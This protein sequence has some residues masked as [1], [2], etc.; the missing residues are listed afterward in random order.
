MSIRT[1]KK[2]KDDVKKV[3]K[4]EEC[5]ICLEEWED[6]SEGDVVEAYVEKKLE[7]EMSHKPGLFLSY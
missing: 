6:I 5:G 4:G 7:H 2:H 1:L 3:L